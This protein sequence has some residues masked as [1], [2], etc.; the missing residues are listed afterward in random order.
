MFPQTDWISCF[1]LSTRKRR[2]NHVPRRCPVDHGFWILHNSISTEERR[3]KA[4]ILDKVAL[5][6]RKLN[7]TE[8]M[9]VDFFQFIHR[10]FQTFEQILLR[11]IYIFKII[12]I[13][14]YIL[15]KCYCC[16][17][18]MAGY[19]LKSLIL[20]H[21]NIDLLDLVFLVL[22]DQVA[23][24]EGGGLCLLLTWCC[25]WCMCLLFL[26]LFCLGV[27]S[28]SQG[29]YSLKMAVVLL[30]GKCLVLFV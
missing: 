24:S 11:K 16:C 25:R 29:Q 5:K 2:V 18:P 30:L 27:H 10:S 19:W 20:L 1:V 21:P 14:L 28:N 13:S 8:K 9:V 26:Q 3:T 12:Y 15:L 4:K 6:L 22:L 23:C 7:E 17:F